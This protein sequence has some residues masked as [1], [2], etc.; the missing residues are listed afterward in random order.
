[1]VTVKSTQ[2]GR[3]RCVVPLAIALLSGS[4]IL[5]AQELQL[6]IRTKVEAETQDS[7]AVA[8]ILKNATTQELLK[9]ALLVETGQLH[10]E[11]AN[12]KPAL[13]KELRIR[14]E[15]AKMLGDR[16]DELANEPGTAALRQNNFDVL[17][18]IGSDES[19]QQI[20]RFLWDER[21]PDPIVDGHEIA[22]EPLNMS[23]AWALMKTLG[24]RAPVDA[25]AVDFY[26]E[27]GLAK[28]QLWWENN[29]DKL[30][31]WERPITRGISAVPKP[32]NQEANNERVEADQEK[33]GQASKTIWWTIIAVLA[34][35][36]VLVAGR[37]A[38]SSSK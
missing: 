29:K 32:M 36:G 14:P 6:D 38:A 4:Q 7:N 16:I 17:T 18:F 19:L 3:R 10:K 37:R 27:G 31:E 20:G 12:T 1:M 11:N 9:L 33:R 13:I 5:P 21:Q 23:A 22:R 2:S 26:N 30:S 35:T 15:H 34:F 28:A 8:T 25:N 24:Q